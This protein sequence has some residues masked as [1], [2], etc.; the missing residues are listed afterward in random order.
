MPLFSVE[1][2]VGRTVQR[3]AGSR[4]FAPVAKHVIPPVDRT[5]NRLT[6]GRFV[7]SS[8]LVPSLVLTAKGAKSGQPRV[9][10]LACAPQDDGT[11]VVVG[12]NFGQ[13][14]HP[15]WTANLLAHPDDVTVTFRGRTVP[16]RAELLTGEER[17]RTW[18]RVTRVWPTYN[19]YVE[20]SGGRELRLFRLD[21]KQ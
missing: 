1:G 16:V 10:P 21:P 7:L 9:T 11:W 17:E 14:K 8:L 3:V 4:G 18:E 5:L 13:T 2:R 15:A 6:R 19:R 12:S 20:L